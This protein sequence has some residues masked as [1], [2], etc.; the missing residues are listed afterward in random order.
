[1]IW[2]LVIAGL[3]FGADLA[4]YNSAVMVTSAANATLLG[5]VS[6][7]FVAL[8]AWMMYGSRPTTR[9]WTGF[10]LSFAGM[11][12]IVGL[13]VVRHPAF[14]YGDVLAVFGSAS[15]GMYLLYV[16][17][18]RA[19]ADALTFSLWAATVGAVALFV[20]CI[21]ARLPLAGFSVRTWSAL[22][23]L[24]LVSQVVGQLCV[25]H[26]MGHVP[27]T[28]SSIVLLLQAPITAVL[29]W[30]LLGEPLHAGQV[31]GGLLVLGGI[32][33]VN[34]NRFARTNGT[35]AASPAAPRTPR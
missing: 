13:D 35:T 10:A 3:F 7:I 19:A 8:G 12:A 22:V 5:I 1:M 20:V 28:A 29:A 33:V 34:S 15:Y 31:A 11:V 23:A 2:T 24:A 17:R 18:G 21:A 9:F 27:A 30:P 4:F 14:G 16:Q 6:P 25:A 32:V 26:A